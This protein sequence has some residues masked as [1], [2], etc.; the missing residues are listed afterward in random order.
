MKIKINEARV[1]AFK[2]IKEIYETEISIID[3]LTE[4][5]DFGWVFYYNSKKFL[6][7]KDRMSMLMGNNPIVVLRSGKIDY[8]NLA[9]GYELALDK[10][11]E[12]LEK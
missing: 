9:W 12:N 10:L 1:L 6:E 7:T 2:K 3:E 5:H 8:L 4:E 11:K